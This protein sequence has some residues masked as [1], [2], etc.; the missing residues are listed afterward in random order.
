LRNSQIFIFRTGK[1][2]IL[3]TP[4]TPTKTYI[5]IIQRFT[6]HHKSIRVERV[7]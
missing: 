1:S 3:L 2:I 7:E 4:L 5:L 6:K